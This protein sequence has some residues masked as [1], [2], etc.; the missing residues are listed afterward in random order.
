M[1]TKYGKKI[2]RE[3]VRGFAVKKAGTNCAGL[4]YEVKKP[5]AIKNNSAIRKVNKIF[6]AVLVATVLICSFNHVNAYAA[7]RG[8]VTGTLSEKSVYGKLTCNEA[9]HRLTVILNYK[10]RSTLTGEAKS[11]TVGNDAFGNNTVVTKFVSAGVHESAS[12]LN[13]VGKV[14]NVVKKN[15]NVTSYGTTIREYW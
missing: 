4:M 3:F 13:V 8:E 12:F 6:S 5:N 14:D 2:I 1:K 7:V 10:T 9:G 11:H 15:F